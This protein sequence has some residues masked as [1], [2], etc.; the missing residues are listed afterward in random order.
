MTQLNTH[1]L[2]CDFLTT[3][4]LDGLVA[5]VSALLLPS[6]FFADIFLTVAVTFQ[7]TVALSLPNSDAAVLQ[8]SIGFA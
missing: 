6:C 2:R 7:G 5:F 4:G 3:I 8:R 1:P